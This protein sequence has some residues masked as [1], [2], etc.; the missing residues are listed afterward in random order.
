MSP[1]AAPYRGVFPV[2]PVE[3]WTAFV[4]RPS[5]TTKSTCLDLLT[6]M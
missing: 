4:T 2:A 5:R 6:S 3:T 1:G